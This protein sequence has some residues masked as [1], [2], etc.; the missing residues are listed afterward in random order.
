M[1]DREGRASL[2][3]INCTPEMRGE[4]RLVVISA[5]GSDLTLCRLAV[6][7][8]PR[9]ERANLNRYFIFNRHWV[10]MVF[11][12]L[13]RTGLEELVRYEEDKLLEKKRKKQEREE[14]MQEIKMKNKLFA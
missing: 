6:L 2:Q 7:P 11:R 9:E 5:L 13:Q 8:L 14:K 1:R 3:L 4:Y 12:R 10:V